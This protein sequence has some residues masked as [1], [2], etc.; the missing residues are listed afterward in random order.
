METVTVRTG[1]Y[2]IEYDHKDITSSLAPFVVSVTYTDHEH[3]KADEVEITVEDRDHLWK[4]SWYPGKG[5]VL[6]LKLGYL[7]EPLLPC[8]S[9]EL[10]EFEFSGPPDQVVLKGLGA[11]IKRALRQE[12]TVAYESA[13]LKDIAKS[14]AERHGFELVEDTVPDIRVARITQNRE[15]DLSF[16]KRVAEKYGY[17][18]KITDNRLVFYDIEELELSDVVYTLSRQDLLRYSLR[19]KT[20]ETYRSCTVSYHDPKTK[21][22]IEHTEDAEDEAAKRD[23]LKAPQRVENKEQAIEACRAALAEKNRKET[24]GILAV[25]GAPQLVA[26]SNVELTGMGNLSGVYHIET[27]THRIDRSGGYSTEL[28]VRLLGTKSKHKE[29]QQKRS[30]APTLALRKGKQ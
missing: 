13:S 20:H 7:D 18:F 11:N 16:L 5:D 26:G 30:E 29:K 12:N 6:T 15:K 17:A 14:V 24:E 28:S 10:D 25:Q 9:F 8:G 19:D 1:R 22:L 23:V 2:V 4:N 21:T 3:G 27:S